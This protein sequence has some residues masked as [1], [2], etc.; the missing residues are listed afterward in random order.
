MLKFLLFSLIA[1]LLINKIS[2]QCER[3]PTVNC[4]IYDDIQ[5]KTFD[6]N[7]YGFLSSCN[8]QL[9]LI[10]GK[11]LSVTYKR[12]PSSLEVVWGGKIFVIT[13]LN[14]VAS[15]TKDG[16]FQGI[17]ST[18]SGVKFSRP[19]RMVVVK[20]VA[21]DM[22]IK[23]DGDTVEIILKNSATTPN[24]L[25]LC[26]DNNGCVN[27][28]LLLPNGQQAASVTAWA[29]SWAT[30]TCT[31]SAFTLTCTQNQLSAAQT[32]CDNLFINNPQFGD[33][34]L[35]AGAFLDICMSSYCSCAL[36]N[37]VDCEC[38][39]L[40]MFVRTCEVGFD[41][42]VSWRGAT[43]CPISCSV[44][45]ES[46]M[47][48][49][50]N[51]KQLDCWEPEVTDPSL[52]DCEEGC[53]CSNGLRLYEDECLTL[54]ECPCFYDGT[55]YASGTTTQQE[56]N[57]CT[58]SNGQWSCTNNDCMVCAECIG[59][60]H[61]T[62]FD[63]KK[64]DF[65]GKCLYYLVRGNGFDIICDH[66]VYTASGI[67]KDI[68]SSAPAVCA[69][70]LINIDGYNIVLGQSQVVTVNGNTIGWFP[71]PNLPDFLI[72]KP[73]TEFVQ[74]TL[75][76]GI[77]IQFTGQWYVRV[78]VP[79]VFH[80]RVE[81]LLGTLTDTQVDDF[82]KPDDTITTDPNEFG[83]SWKVPGSCENENVA[84]PIHPC[85]VNPSREVNAEN[86]CSPIIS[87]LFAG[88]SANPQADYEDCVY[89]GCNCEDDDTRCLCEHFMVQ[90]RKCFKNGI[91]VNWRDTITQC[92]VTCPS[93]QTY[94][95]CG[96]SCQTCDDISLSGNCVEECEGGCRCPAGQAMNYNDQC[97]PINQCTCIW[98]GARFSA[99][100]YFVDK[101]QALKYTCVN[102]RWVI[103]DS[104]STEI[105][106]PSQDC[107]NTF[108]VY[109]GCK[110]TNTL[111]CYNK[112]LEERPNFENC[113]GGCECVVGFVLD[114]AIGVCVRPEECPCI[115]K[116][117]SYPDNSVISNREERC[118]CNA[119][120]WECIPET[121]HWETCIASGDVHIR[122]FDD[123]IFSFE[124][125][126]EYVVFF[127][128]S[129]T[130]GMIRAT[131]ESSSCPTGACMR[132][133]SI[134]RRATNG[135]T[136]T[137]IFNIDGTIVQSQLTNLIMTDMGASVLVDVLNAGIRFVWNRSGQLQVHVSP[138]WLTQHSSGLCGQYDNNPANDLEVPGKTL[139]GVVDFV[140]NWKRDSSC[141]SATEIGPYSML[142]PDDPCEYLKNGVFKT[143]NYLVPV[144][145]WL[146]KCRQNSQQQ[147]GVPP[148]QRKNHYCA[149]ISSYAQLCTEAGA[150]V[151][152]RTATMC[153]VSCT[154]NKALFPCETPCARENCD[155]TVGFN[156]PDKI[157]VEACKDPK[158]PSGQVYLDGTNTQ[159]VP[160]SQCPATRRLLRWL[161]G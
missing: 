70:V 25:G 136:E 72:S 9:L 20:I 58:C 41:M 87:S 148:A 116:G 18:T 74:V 83:H 157:C 107:P 86:I 131:I 101:D 144:E 93:G 57:S 31:S 117:I 124:G 151:D 49:A 40:D 61:C 30:T 52:Y 79:W 44:P 53:Y 56:C 90:E 80:N 110:R 42:L 104:S 66:Y 85:L 4:I 159:C 118:T 97:V 126:C 113:V 38:S 99:G 6:G 1:I 98:N 102:G 138:L 108:L 141:A 22:K 65:Q 112:H 73:T 145:P 140:N 150:P 48:C 3:S 51:N 82:T 106:D 134:H 152:W 122:S 45:D 12:N 77:T 156:C 68:T 153:P 88:C 46:Y 133:A 120:L 64:Y 161:N 121:D 96:S 13:L 160:V 29:D 17:P 114:T 23:Y 94:Q 47:R 155:N 91:T 33:C 76:N 28:D 34:T 111:T 135:V 84:E 36:S 81:G 14:N 32:F 139:N 8:Y 7:V 37:A 128:Q 123:T 71:Y 105:T 24:T 154:G 26:A 89:D 95:A 75:W 78:C 142:I 103:T 158:C 35:I 54:S 109:A 132:T 92:S 62:T 19:G 15:L 59:D 69:R 129:P 10:P 149:V 27:D 100:N 125:Y 60:P 39:M 119:G 115:Y 63:G 147:K 127:Y 50:H 2:A 21:L 16:N 67:Y 137:I 130:F 5:V 11:G 43:M 146:E 55:Y 143:C